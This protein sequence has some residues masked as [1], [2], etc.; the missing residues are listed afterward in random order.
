MYP[1]EAGS[2]NSVGYPDCLLMW[3]CVRCEII[4]YYGPQM[5]Q[6]KVRTKGKQPQLQQQRQQHQK[7]LVASKF[8]SSKIAKQICVKFLFP[9]KQPE[10]LA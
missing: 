2:H 5:Q 8:L 10:Q 9:H 3:L 4:A 7:Q 1:A 6:F